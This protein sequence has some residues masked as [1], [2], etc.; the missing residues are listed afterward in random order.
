MTA[1]QMPLTLL[2]RSLQPLRAHFNQRSGWRMLA[3]L[4]P[5]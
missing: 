1:H 3:L 2:N 4:S 5:T